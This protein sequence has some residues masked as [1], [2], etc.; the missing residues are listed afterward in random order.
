M[1]PNTKNLII[2]CS[3][4]Q[5]DEVVDIVGNKFN[6]R[7]KTFTYKDSSDP[8]V[9]FDDRR[10]YREDILEDFSN[11]EYDCLVAMHCLDEG[12]DIP[13]ASKAILLCNSTNP[14]EFI[15]R[16]GRVLRR[17]PGKNKAEIY[18]LII[19]LSLV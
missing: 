5:I 18:D 1:G 10:S 17:S 2:Y 4:E 9:N 19:I 16:L 7:V 14:R 8:S 3:D 11:G 12:V 6:W 15:Q 13:S